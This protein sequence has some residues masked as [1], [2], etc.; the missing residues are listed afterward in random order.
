[1]WCVSSNTTILRNF[2]DGLRYC[3]NWFLRSY[4]K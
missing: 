3:V 2:L 1:V 4:Y